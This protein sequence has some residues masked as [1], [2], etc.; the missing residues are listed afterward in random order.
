MVKC[1]KSIHKIWPDMAKKHQQ[2]NKT[3]IKWH[4]DAAATVHNDIKIG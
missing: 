4:P 3:L 2:A 1:L